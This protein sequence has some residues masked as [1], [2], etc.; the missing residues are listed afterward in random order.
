MKKLN[1]KN[2]KIKI[3]GRSKKLGKR[4]GSLRKKKKSTKSVFKAKGS[5]FMEAQKVENKIIN[6]SN[7]EVTNKLESMATPDPQELKL[8]LESQM[9]FLNPNKKKKKR[10]SSRKLSSNRRNSGL[11]QNNESPLNEKRKVEDLNETENDQQ[12]EQSEFENAKS[13]LLSQNQYKKSELARPKSRQRVFSKLNK[14]INKNK[15]DFD[16]D[17]DISSFD[18][19]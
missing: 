17:D 11:I 9:N 15:E 19:E 2:G 12:N 16:N 7:E 10:R 13:I 5:Q 14:E 6:D 4:R 18:I 1:Q 8:N 3:K